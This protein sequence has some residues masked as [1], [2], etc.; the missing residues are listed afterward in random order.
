MR[1]EEGGA[2]RRR[3]RGES[4]V[5]R[6]GQLIGQKFIFVPQNDNFDEVSYRQK[7]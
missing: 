2:R 7:P 3:R 5:E 1:W 4:M 6:A